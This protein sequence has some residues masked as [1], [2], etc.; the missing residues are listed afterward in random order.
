MRVKET[1]GQDFSAEVAAAASTFR[2]PPT[3]DAY[4]ASGSGTHNR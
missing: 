4:I 2:V 3:F 1:N